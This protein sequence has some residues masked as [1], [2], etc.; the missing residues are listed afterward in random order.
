MQKFFYY[1]SIAGALAIIL[2]L[3]PIF[4]IHRPEPVWFAYFLMIFP[5]IIL[6]SALLN[7]FFNKQKKLAIK[8]IVLAVV[9]FFAS[10]SIIAGVGI[11][12]FYFGSGLSGLQKIVFYL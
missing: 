1:F 11:W 12:N 6:I 7:L 2:A 4:F 8:I 9:I 10:L 3:T 5:T